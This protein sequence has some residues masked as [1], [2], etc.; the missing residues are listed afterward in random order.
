MNACPRQATA[1]NSQ[2]A[3]K[4]ARTRLLRKAG[5][6]KRAGKVTGEFLPAGSIFHTF[7]I[8]AEGGFPSLGT[9][10]RIPQARPREIG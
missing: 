9:F 5:R 10:Q 8:H 1:Y 7:W 2:E 6:R 4:V 3:Q